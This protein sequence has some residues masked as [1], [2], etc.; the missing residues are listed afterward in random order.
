MA[1]DRKT[2]TQLAPLIFDLKVILAQPKQSTSHASQDWQ[3]NVC[4]KEWK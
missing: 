4:G 3:D 2:V 1:P